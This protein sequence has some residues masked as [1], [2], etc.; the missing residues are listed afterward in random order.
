MDREKSIV[1]WMRYCRFY[2][3][4]QIF[5]NRCDAGEVVD[6]K[7]VAARNHCE[8]HGIKATGAPCID[9]HLLKDMRS[10]CP[11]WER[12]TRA[13]A[14]KT[15]NDL[16]A[17]SKKVMLVM[18]VIAKW[19]KQLPIGKQ[20]VIECPVCKGRLHLSQAAVNGHVHGKCETQDCVSWME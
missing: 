11:K 3:T 8:A 16:D 20:A 13:E 15:A 12:V 9:G 5:S 18:P 17:A 4:G 2:K 19:R 10:V 7:R 14:E 1:H 6:L